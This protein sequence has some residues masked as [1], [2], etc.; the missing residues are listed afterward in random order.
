MINDQILDFS[1][2]NKDGNPFNHFLVTSVLKNNIDKKLHSWLESTDFWGHTET[3]FYTQYEFSLLEVEIPNE[4]KILLSDNTINLI[5]DEF[6]IICNSKSLELVGLTVHKLIDG[7]KIGVHNDFIGDE[8]SHRFLI[9]INENWNEDK[10]GF[11]M[12]FNSMNSEDVSKIIAP[13]NNTGFGFEISPKSFHAVS[14]VYSFSRYTLVYTFK[15][16]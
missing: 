10:G 11:L 9:Q 2:L 15:E 7:Y 1:T 6:T 5:R 4:L 12:L 16:I 8:E 13:F 14:T 3:D